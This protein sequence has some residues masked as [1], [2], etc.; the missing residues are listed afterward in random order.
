MIKS[1]VSADNAPIKI[2]IPITQSTIV[3]E[4]KMHMKNGRKS[5]MD[6][7]ICMDVHHLKKIQLYQVVY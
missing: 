3:N 7:D 1:D 4:P 2:D 6:K 5:V